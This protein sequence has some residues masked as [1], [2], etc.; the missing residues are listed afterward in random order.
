MAWGDL[1]HSTVTG[2]LKLAVSKGPYGKVSYP[3]SYVI[4]SHHPGHHPQHLPSS[5]PLL[6]GTATLSR[7][8]PTCRSVLLVARHTRG[9]H[10]GS[11]QCSA[12]ATAH[13]ESPEVPILDL[14]RQ[15]SHCQ[16]QV[17]QWEGPSIASQPCCGM[18]SLESLPGFKSQAPLGWHSQPQLHLMQLLLHQWDCSHLHHRNT[19]VDEPPPLAANLL[20]SPSEA[21][22]PS[23]FLRHLHGGREW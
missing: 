23:H 11:A 19:Q 20:Q 16:L 18:K 4:P 6:W 13:P 14:Q 21:P 10:V 1:G 5:Q 2:W 3:R 9:A 22:S 7:W 15:Q 12:P 8:I 17:P